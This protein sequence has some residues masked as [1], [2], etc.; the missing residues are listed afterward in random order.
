M[1]ADAN[2]SL[3]AEGSGLIVIGFDNGEGVVIRLA[4]S[5]DE[6]RG[7]IFTS[8]GTSCLF[9]V[10]SEVLTAGETEVGFAAGFGRLDRVASRLAAWSH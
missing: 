8:L 7:G 1:T 5:V 6:A 9:E 4:A 3:E 2:E 10:C